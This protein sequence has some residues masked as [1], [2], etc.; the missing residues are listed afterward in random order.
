MESLICLLFIGLTLIRLLV[1]GIREGLHFTN[2]EWTQWYLD[3]H[4]IRTID[5]II[6]GILLVYLIGFWLTLGTLMF[7]YCLIYERALHYIDH[8]QLFYPRSS[9]DLWTL[10][11]PFS[12]TFMIIIAILGLIIII[13]NVM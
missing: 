10:K 2:H 9:W 11:I 3:Y 13:I 8:K 1:T 6:S 7:G 5:V 4:F 12:N